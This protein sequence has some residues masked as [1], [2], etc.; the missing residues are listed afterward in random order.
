MKTVK[1]LFSKE[2]V[3]FE[4]EFFRKFKDP[5]F[6]E[7]LIN[8]DA[9]GAK[10]SVKMWAINFYMSFYENSLL[11]INDGQLSKFCSVHYAPD[12]LF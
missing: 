10:R 6:L 2:N 3:D 4:F 9:K 8:L 7:K 1:S 11:Y 12:G 5:L